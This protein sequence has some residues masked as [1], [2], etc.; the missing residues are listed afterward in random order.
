MSYYRWETDRSDVHGPCVCRPFTCGCDV[1]GCVRE[2]EAMWPLNATTN[3]TCSYYPNGY[4][5]P[6]IRQAT[7]LTRL[8]KHYLKFELGLIA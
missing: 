7:G 8:K 6:Y 4:W 1:C 2:E 5:P 3:W